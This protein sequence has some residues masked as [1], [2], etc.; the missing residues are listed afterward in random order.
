MQKTRDLESLTL[1]EDFWSKY[2][3]DEINKIF[4]ELKTLKEP[5]E[6]LN[7]IETEIN[8]LKEMINI[9]E[10]E[11][12]ED[13]SKE[14]GLEIPNLFSKLSNL[15]VLQLFTGKYD[16]FNAI[17]TLQAG[18]GGTEAQDWVQMLY[19]MYIKWAGSNNF[20]LEEIDILDGDEAGIKSVTFIIK[21]N[22]AY[23]YLKSEIG[24]HRLVRISPFDASKKRH[25]SFASFECLPEIDNDI[26]IDI[27][28]E[29]LRID[30]YRASGAGGQHVN[31]TSSAVR[32][33]HIPTNI[34]VTCQSD[35]SQIKNRDT[36]M[37]LL[38]SKLYQLEEERQR[39]EQKEL[40]G[41]HSRIEWGSQIRSYIFHPYSLVKDHRT[42]YEVGNVES[43]MDGD[44][45]EF[46]RK[47]LEYELK[48]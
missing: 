4:K 34:I 44:L 2:N 40:L 43:V 17:C 32:I 36:A 30:T 46:M 48:Q 15:K 20:E 27:N 41:D 26:E 31:K 9:L 45:I 23:G 18:A 33:T 5:I 3:Q 47:Y 37:K 21:G 1:Q 10:I 22:F 11:Y 7:N 6:N 12:D 24:V 13:L 19:R 25:T 16:N 39:D 28:E 14:I 35:R 8:N 42:N 38:K 29:D